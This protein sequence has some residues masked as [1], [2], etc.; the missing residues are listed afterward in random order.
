MFVYI[1][2]FLFKNWLFNEV[3][4]YILFYK[5]FF[6]SKIIYKFIFSIGDRLKKVYGL[7]I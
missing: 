5:C 7:F 2:Y 1:I 6:I 3:Y 4:F